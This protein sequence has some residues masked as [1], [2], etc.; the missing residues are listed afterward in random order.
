MIE[1]PNFYPTFPDYLQ[2][3]TAIKPVMYWKKDETT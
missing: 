1:R 2:E 3:S